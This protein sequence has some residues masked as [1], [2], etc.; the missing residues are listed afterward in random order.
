MRVFCNANWGGTDAGS[1]VAFL[2]GELFA[3]DFFQNGTQLLCCRIANFIPGKQIKKTAEAQTSAVG[4]LPV[5]YQKSYSAS[6][7]FSAAML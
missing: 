1:S 5:I 7:Q 4:D 6:P 2:D 3:V